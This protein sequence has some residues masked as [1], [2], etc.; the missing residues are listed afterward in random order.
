MKECIELR[1]LNSLSPAEVFDDFINQRGEFGNPWYH[2]LERWVALELA[3]S[4]SELGL[5]G[6]SGSYNMLHAMAEQD[7][8]HEISYLIALGAGL[9]AEDSRR[10]TPLTIASFCKCRG[11]IKVLLEAGASIKHANMKKY[12]TLYDTVMKNDATIAKLL[13]QKDG[14]DFYDSALKRL[15]LPNASVGKQIAPPITSSVPDRYYSI[16]EI[17]VF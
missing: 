4:I 2:T 5:R 8:H 6:F 1:R 10:R 7:R 16:L 9:E 11:A 17:A 12:I 15:V 13:I 14:D 3:E